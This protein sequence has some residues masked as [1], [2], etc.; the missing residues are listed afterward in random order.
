MAYFLLAMFAI[1]LVGCKGPVERDPRT[2]PPL[3]TVTTVESPTE[4]SSF[5]QAW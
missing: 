4:A 2:Q 1:V 3:V 5:S